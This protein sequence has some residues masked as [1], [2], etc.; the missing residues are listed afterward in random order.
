[1]V[2]E[3]YGLTQSKWLTNNLLWTQL[4]AAGYHETQTTPGLWRHKWHPI[5]FVFI[6]EKFGVDYIGKQH[7]DHLLSILNKHYEM[8]ED[9]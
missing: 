1:M 6:V 2:R 3:A 4:N 9:W 5:Q 7:A 8:S